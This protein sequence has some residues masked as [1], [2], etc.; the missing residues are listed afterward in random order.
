MAAQVCSTCNKLLENGDVVRADIETRFVAL[1][2]RITYA[3]EKPIE[4]FSVRH[5]NCNYPA[6]MP[7]E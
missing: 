5:S 2:S 6:G 4:C 3:L 1:K 7:E